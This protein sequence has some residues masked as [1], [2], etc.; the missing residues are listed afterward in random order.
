[1]SVLWFSGVMNPGQFDSRSEFLPNI[2][3]VFLLDTLCITQLSSDCP[4]GVVCDCSEKESHGISGDWPQSADEPHSA[5]GAA[6]LP[7]LCVVETKMSPV[8]RQVVGKSALSVWQVLLVTFPGL[9]FLWPWDV[10]PASQN[11][12]HLFA[13]WILHLYSFFLLVSFYLFKLSAFLGLC[14][15]SHFVAFPVPVI[16]NLFSICDSSMSILSLLK[17]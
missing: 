6:L 7:F 12:S 14:K 13:D 10:P 8:W 11:C 16:E 1:M 15:I 5:S 9:G 4:L 3:T 2:S 17:Y